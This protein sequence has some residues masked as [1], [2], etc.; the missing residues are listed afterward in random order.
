MD[1]R[2]IDFGIVTNKSSRFAIPLMR[3]YNLLD[4]MHTLVCGDQVKQRKPNPEPL[5]KALKNSGESYNLNNVY[6][7]GDAQKDIDA[8]RAAHFRSIACTY[9]YRVA[10]DN[11]A[12]WE[13]EFLI[14]DLIEVNGI[15]W[16]S[17]EK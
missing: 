9:G 14:D 2:D 17:T 1:S 13:A 3:Q 6:Y 11:P 8:A 5:I 12:S 10:D 16:T 7:V 15:V 4:R